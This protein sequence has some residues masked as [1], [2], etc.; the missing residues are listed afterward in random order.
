[1]KPNYDNTK[2]VDEKLRLQSSFIY[3]II[4]T[5]GREE[6]ARPFSS[7]AWSGFVA[8]LCITFSLLGE[9][10]MKYHYTG[11]DPFLIVNL[12]YTFG[13]LIVILGRFQLFTENTIT[14][15]LPLLEDRRVKNLIRTLKLWAIV[16]FT[17]FIGTFSVAVL[18]VL[19]PFVGPEMFD[20]IIE[21]SE[22]AVNRDP[23]LIFFQAMPAGFLIAA[24]VWMLPS[25]EGAAHFFVVI[26]M[27]YLIAI[28]D[29]AHIVAGSVEAFLLVLEGHISITACVLYL[30]AACG[31]NVIGGTGLFAVM[32]YAQVKEEM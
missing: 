22:H 28:G 2:D 32:A 10:F 8:G 6:L 24:L 5:E 14:V 1:M 11:D 15:V 13:F 4:S 21:I 16:L 12:G 27:T 30:L 26:L 25:C 19:L 3:E 17:N 9:A 20:V 29:F 23:W 18:L 7:L 31:G